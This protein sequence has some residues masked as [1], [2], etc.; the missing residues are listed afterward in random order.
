MWSIYAEQNLLSKL[1][2][3][4]PSDLYSLVTKKNPLL[5]VERARFKN[6]SNARLPDTTVYPQPP[7]VK[8]YIDNYTKIRDKHTTI[9][10][11]NTMQYAGNFC[12]PENLPRRLKS[13]KVSED[14]MHEREDCLKDHQPAP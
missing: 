2:Q 8:K 13:L 1:P 12:I 6:I 9:Q 3:K 10:L 11:Y 5:P 7:S 4:L 14:Q